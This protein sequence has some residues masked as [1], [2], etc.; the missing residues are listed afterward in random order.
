MLSL[1]KHSQPFFINL[2]VHNLG[3]RGPFLQAVSIV[4]LWREF[5]KLCTG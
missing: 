2:L 5:V 3:E 4:L 1:S